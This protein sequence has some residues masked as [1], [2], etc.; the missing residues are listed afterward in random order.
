MADYTTD[1]FIV[2]LNLHDNVTKQIEQFSKQWF[3]AIGQIEKRLNE[4][5]NKA[6]NIP[7]GGSRPGGGNGQPRTPNFDMAAFRAANSQMLNKMMSGTRQQVMQALQ[8]RSRIYA[9]QG[10]TERNGGDLNSFRRRLIGINNDL[11][12]WQSRNSNFSNRM[13]QGA[14]AV[15]KMTQGANAA[16]SGLMKIVAASYAIHRMFD[17][18][19]SAVERGVERQKGVLSMQAAYT[20]PGEPTAQI[21]AVKALSDE[22]GTNFAE[23]LQQ[24]AMLKNVLP[25]GTSDETIAQF[26]RGSTVLGRTTGMSDDA[27]KRMSIA[28]EK[29]SASGK[30]I[31]MSWNSM[32]RN[33]PALLAGMARQKGLQNTSDLRDR[34]KG[35]GGAAAAREI[36]DYIN[37]YPDTL[38]GN[39]KSN[40]QNVADSLQTK[41]AK[42]VNSIGDASDIFTRGATNGIGQLSD[43]IV[44]FVKQNGWA[45]NTI[46]EAVG[47]ITAAFARGVEYLNTFF[48]HLDI[49]R[50][51]I[52]MWYNG[53]SDTTKKFISQFGQYAADLAAIMIGSGSLYAAFNMLKWATWAIIKPFNALG[54]LLKM[55]TGAKAGVAA[56]TTAEGEL[57][58]GSVLMAMGG[59]EVLAGIAV[60]ALAAYGLSKLWDALKPNYDPKTLDKS[61]LYYH[62]S[63]VGDTIDGAKGVWNRL[64]SSDTFKSLQSYDKQNMVSADTY[65]YG[66]VMSP[67][68]I[69]IRVTVDPVKTS[70]DI[71]VKPDMDSFNHHI[72]GVAEATAQTTYDSK[73]F[74]QSALFRQ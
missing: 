9:A 73:Q 7:G 24:S 1:N 11:R 72:E 12:T 23:A 19:E 29:L 48:N 46:G 70:A 30:N 39:G 6:R 5:L 60:A 28:V 49:L 17:F 68:N 37:K 56:A 64:T 27:I 25:H 31:G 47:G 40:A 61:G 33:A 16:H 15:S 44:N 74:N 3:S 62:D 21:R 26:H 32:I 8:T 18:V 66:R 52:R 35:E 45:F 34:F 71:S 69:N 36:I 38:A 14:A 58:A 55:L 53:L 59:A 50:L 10:E 43:S 13:T 63:L 42:I 41:L 20:A 2:E 22:F 51:T 54:G 65:D 57:A 67:Q 4:M